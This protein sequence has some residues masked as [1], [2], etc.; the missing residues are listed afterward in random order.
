M[1]RRDSQKRTEGKARSIVRAGTVVDARTSLAIWLRTGRAQKGLSLDD[2]ARITKIQPRILE[3]LE[4]GKHDGLPADVF[5]RGFV[6]SFAKCVGLDEDEALRRY[7]A[8]GGLAA[9][10]GEIT[11]AA[12]ALVDAM[13]ELAP[14]VARATPRK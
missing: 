8:C 1:E 2:V 3:R 13:S 10:S 12:R 9:G 7:A 4:A 11:P 14:T 6:R 5:V